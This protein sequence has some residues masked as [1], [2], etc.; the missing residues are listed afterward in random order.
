MT[1]TIDAAVTF[2]FMHMAEEKVLQL[3]DPQP[4]AE[5]KDS[6]GD[7]GCDISFDQ[8]QVADFIVEQFQDDQSN[9]EEGESQSDE[10]VD[11]AFGESLD[12]FLRSMIPAHLRDDNDEGEVGLSDE[13]EGEPQ[14]DKPVDGDQ[15]GEALGE[16]NEDVE[17]EVQSFKL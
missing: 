2:T 10:S 16:P 15:F 9:E 1:K 8:S 11:E 7:S 14:S 5:C 13:E 12:D 3:I 6:T 17:E 4:S